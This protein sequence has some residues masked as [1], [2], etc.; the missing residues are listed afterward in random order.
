[1][2]DRTSDLSGKLWAA[3]RKLACRPG[4]Y[5]SGRCRRRRA[6]IADSGGGV[7]DSPSF[8]FSSGT[9]STAED[10]CD[11]P[12][13]SRPGSREAFCRSLAG[14]RKLGFFEGYQAPVMLIP[15]GKPYARLAFADGDATDIP[16]FRMVPQNFPEPV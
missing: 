14:E 6:D 11:L 13:A 3:F 1:M 12:S 9:L 7:I 2:R 16:K 8:L 5:T 15:K 4:R 10:R